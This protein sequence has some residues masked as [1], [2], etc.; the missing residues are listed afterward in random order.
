MQ[1]AGL[2]VMAVLAISFVSFLVGYE[3]GYHDGLFR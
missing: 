3:K 1:L 2:I